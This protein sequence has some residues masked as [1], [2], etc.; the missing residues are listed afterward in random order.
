MRKYNFVDP[1]TREEIFVQKYKIVFRSGG[2]VYLD[3]FDKELVNSNGVPLEL[4]PL[5]G[6]FSCNLGSSVAQSKIKLNRYLKAR[7]KEHFRKDV[8]Y[9]KSQMV[10]NSKPGY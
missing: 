6:E 7:S 9:R 5:S 8:A 1:D 2:I 10:R 3:R 4:I